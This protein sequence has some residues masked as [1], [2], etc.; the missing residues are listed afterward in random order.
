MTITTNA[1]DLIATTDALD[2]A[3]GRNGEYGSYDYIPAG[4]SVAADR[5]TIADTDAPMPGVSF[6]AFRGDARR[7]TNRRSRHSAK[8]ALRG[9][10]VDAQAERDEVHDITYLQDMSDL[11]QEERE[12]AQRFADRMI[13]LTLPLIRAYRD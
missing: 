5:A 10:V 1:I 3:I 12:V 4:H 13:A 6:T 2:K 8:A 7:E 11:A 9:F